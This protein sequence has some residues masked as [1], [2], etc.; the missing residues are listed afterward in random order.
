M[1]S[2]LMFLEGGQNLLQDS[3]QD[4]N[5]QYIIALQRYNL[6]MG[7]NQLFKMRLNS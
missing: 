4:V 7:K 2:G 6:Q 1:T 5:C 3:I